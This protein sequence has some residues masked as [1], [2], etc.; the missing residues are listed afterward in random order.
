MFGEGT[1]VRRLPASVQEQQL[2]IAAEQLHI[3][4]MLVALS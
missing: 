3:L 4:R 1:G 2:L